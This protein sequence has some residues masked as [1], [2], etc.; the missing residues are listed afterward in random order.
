MQKYNLEI[1]NIKK[2]LL[3]LPICG[4]FK[5]P[6]IHFNRYCIDFYYFE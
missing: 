4:L 5:S 2:Y 1:Q 6:D 3:P